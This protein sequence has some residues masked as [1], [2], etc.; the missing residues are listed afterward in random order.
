ME[1]F[2]I[3]NKY[4]L[5]V[6]RSVKYNN[7]L[8]ILLANGLDYFQI[9]KYI[10][11]S[12]ELGYVTD[13]SELSITSDGDKKII[14]LCGKFGSNKKFITPKTSDKIEKISKDSIYIP[15][16]TTKL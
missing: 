13:V 6:L 8:D 1:N 7:S 5:D 10:E 3:K 9:V 12:I 15:K 16:K 11:Q 2:E 14:E 4:L